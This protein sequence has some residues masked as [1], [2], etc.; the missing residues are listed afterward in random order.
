MICSLALAGVIYL[1]N[2]PVLAGDPMAGADIAK[3][4]CTACHATGT[5]PAA[6]DVG[7]PFAEIAN[8]PMRTESRLR[9][10]LADPHPPMPN[11]GLSRVEIENVIAYLAS[12]RT[13]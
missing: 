4:W 1:V 3:R 9:T 12:L 2:G 13:K 6:R 7:P 10:W 8:D 11:P 5:S